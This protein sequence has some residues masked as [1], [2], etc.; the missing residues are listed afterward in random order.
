MSYKER[1]IRSEFVYP[2]VCPNF[3]LL[4]DFALRKNERQTEKKERKMKERKKDI[5]LNFQRQVW[6]SLQF[7]GTYP[8]FDTETSTF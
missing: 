3:L 8:P 6:E 2:F 5:I 1:S 7:C 4:I